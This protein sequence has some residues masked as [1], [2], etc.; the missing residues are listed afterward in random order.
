MFSKLALKNVTRS[1]RDYSVYFLTLT[2]GVCIFYVFNSMDAQY[3]MEALKGGNNI[4]RTIIQLIDVISVFVSVVLAFLILYANSFM[5]RRRKKELGTYLL[6]GMGTGAISGLLFLETL[7]IGLLSLGVGLALGVFLSQFISVF[8]AS[9]FAIDVPEFHFVFSPRA[10]GKTVLYFGVIFLVV[11]CF[12]SLSVSRCKLLDLMQAGKRNQELKVKNLGVSAVLFVVGAVLLGIAYAMLLYRGIL[13]VDTLFFV[14]L[15]LGTAG[16]LLFFLSLSGFLL[17]VCQANKKLYYKGLNMFILRQFNSRINSTYVSMTV[18]CLML[19]L[20]IGITA[21]S[22]GLNNTISQLTNA[23]APYDVSLAAQRYDAAT[24]EELPTDIPGALKEAGFDPE[25]QLSQSAEV[26][27]WQGQLYVPEWDE[28]LVEHVLPLS[29]YN[30]LRS[31]EGLEPI[32]LE[33]STYLWVVGVED[34]WM[35]RLLADNPSLVANHHTLTAGADPIHAA[36]SIG[37]SS[38]AQNYLIIPDEV[39]E[40]A[41]DWDT[42]KM[43]R[44]VTYYCANYRT[45]VPKEDTEALLRSVLS[46]YYRS[47]LGEDAGS[48]R[49]YTKLEVYQ[50]TMGTKIL[51]LFLGIY[52]GII[53]LL[54]SAAVL[55]LQQLSQAADNQERYAVL[56]RLGVE[57]KM[58]DRSVYVQVFLA[59]FLPLFLAVIHAVVGMTAANRVILSV[60]KLDAVASSAVTAVFIL[61]VYGAYF[62]AT[63]WGSRRIV[64]GR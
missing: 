60:G 15:A 10:L 45:D 32:T 35:T 47:V 2:F 57:E 53:F 8:T 6:L 59:F 62:L 37:Y 51:V 21:C 24:G 36:L 61:V 50:E 3:V 44:N 64:R 28:Y 58:R 42:S 46:D 63:C 9:L 30:G 49:T 43:Y 34:E 29:S 16:T 41:G 31:L 26:E 39:L 14:M 4:A 12:N 38:E 5:V 33:P 27:L 18:I 20:A 48:T 17:R 25:I 11:M 52:L 13:R 54:T 55:A 40:G 23:Q 7:L 1:L 56:T 19:L 22:I